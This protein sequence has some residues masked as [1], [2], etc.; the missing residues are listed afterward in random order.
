MNPM[1]QQRAHFEAGISREAIEVKYP[2]ATKASMTANQ[3]IYASV[4]ASALTL[5]EPGLF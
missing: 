2:D 4:V 5:A 1:L 3:C